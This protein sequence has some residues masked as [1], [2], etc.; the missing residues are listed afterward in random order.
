MKW[1]IIFL[2][3]ILLNCFLESLQYL[4]GMPC[5]Y[6]WLILTDIINICLCII[7]ILLEEKLKRIK[8]KQND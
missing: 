5:H 7:V 6:S 8:E 4:K 1:N 2:C 3:V